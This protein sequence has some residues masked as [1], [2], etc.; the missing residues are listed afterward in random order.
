L[1]EIHAVEAEAFY[2]H[3]GLRAG[4]GGDRGGG[5]DVEGGDTAFAAVDV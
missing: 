5:I 2:F 1:E 3:Q 4:G